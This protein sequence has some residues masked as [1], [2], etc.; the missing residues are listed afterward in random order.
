MSSAEVA[1]AVDETDRAFDRRYDA[2]N[3][4]GQEG[5]PGKPLFQD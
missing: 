1:S 3:K 2:I 5:P 4:F